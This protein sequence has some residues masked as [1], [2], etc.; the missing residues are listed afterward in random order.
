[1]AK[2]SC[3][4]C[5]PP[6]RHPGCHAT[7]PDYEKDDAEHQERK[8]AENKRKKILYGLTGQRTSAVAKAYK[9]RKAKKGVSGG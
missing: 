5:I 9:K 1:M 6:R 7:C 8:A 4:G 2:R 3:Y